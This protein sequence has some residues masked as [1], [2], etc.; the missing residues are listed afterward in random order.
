MKRYI[1]YIV[2]IPALTAMAACSK[3]EPQQAGEQALVI[4][5]EGITK[6]AQNYAPADYFGLADA[7]LDFSLASVKCTGDNYNRAADY[8]YDAGTLKA[9]SSATMLY[10]PVGPIRVEVLWPSTAVRT[11]IGAAVP[12]DQTEKV[13]FLSADWLS[14]T[15]TNVS[16]QA[17]LAVTLS[18][19]RSKVSFATA[20]GDKITALTYKG[21]DAYCDADGSIKEAQLIL[22]A[23]AQATLLNTTDKGWA[24]VNGGVVE[25]TLSTAPALAAGSNNTIT[26]TIQ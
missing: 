24:M 4:R 2:L 17:S 6:A 19:Q 3:S 5:V 23:T 20:S 26:L 1:K 14:A 11:A 7:E 12:T 25:F 16:A 10:Y 21:F 18:H 15:L 8:V 9:A 22:D 13:D